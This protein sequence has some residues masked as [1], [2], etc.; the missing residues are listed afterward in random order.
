LR[1]AAALA[2]SILAAATAQGADRRVPVDP[3]QPPWSAV[4]KVQTN[5]GG[6]CSG[7]LIAP[8]VVLTAAHCLYNPRTLTMLQPVS[9]HVLLGYERGEYRWHR[10]V[11]RVTVGLGY[12]GGR[13]VPQ[14]SDWARLDLAEPVAVTPLPLASKVPLVPP[15]GMAVALAGYNQD[16][17]QLLMAD[18]D[19]HVRRAGGEDHAIFLSHDCAGTRGTSGGPLLARQGEN[20]V[21]VGIEIAAGEGFNLALLPPVA[22]LLSE[23]PP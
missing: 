10:Q 22:E 14:T 17:A 20:W 1:I 8:T 18:L 12:D 16:K 6:K 4:A 19:C 13:T 5:I 9:L 21:V 7:V 2:L 15:V 11:T 23:R 3:N